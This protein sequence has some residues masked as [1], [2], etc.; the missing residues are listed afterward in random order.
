[1]AEIRLSDPGDPDPD[2]R[3]GGDWRVGDRGPAREWARPTGDEAAAMR[4]GALRLWTVEVGRYNRVVVDA[5]RGDT[6]D[7]CKILLSTGHENPCALTEDSAAELAEDLHNAI[8]W[9]W[10]SAAPE[11]REE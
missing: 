1:M 8:A 2:A 11:E 10:P 4:S 5:R 7:E 6:G 9:L 3:G